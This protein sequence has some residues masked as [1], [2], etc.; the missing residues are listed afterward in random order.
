MYCFLTFVD[1][2]GY[3]FEATVVVVIVF[4]ILS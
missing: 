1:G 4:F 3:N 2:K